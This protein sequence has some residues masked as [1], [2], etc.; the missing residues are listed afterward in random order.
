MVTSEVRNGVNVFT[1][2]AGTPSIVRG[3][4]GVKF[5]K[6]GDNWKLDV[7]KTLAKVVKRKDGKEIPLGFSVLWEDDNGQHYTACTAG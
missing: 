6:S 7:P 3:P 4:S 5:S 2:I 1:G